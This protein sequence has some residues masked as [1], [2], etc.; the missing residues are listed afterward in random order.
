MLLSPSTVIVTITL[1]PSIAALITVLSVPDSP[2]IVTPALSPDFEEVFPI[3]ISISEELPVKMI[4]AVTL[5][6][7]EVEDPLSQLKSILLLLPVV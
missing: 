4:E 7:P 6:H 3:S 2:K 5:S 1:V